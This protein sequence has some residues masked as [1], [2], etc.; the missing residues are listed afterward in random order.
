VEGGSLADEDGELQER[1]AGLLANT[2]ATPSDIPPSFS[3]IL[4]QLE[5]MDA[6]LLDRIFDRLNVPGRNWQEEAVDA[7]IA[8]FDAEVEGLSLE[9]AL[10]NLFRL[11]LITSQATYGE[12]VS[13][14]VMLTALGREFVTACR[15]PGALAEVQAPRGVVRRP[16]AG[17]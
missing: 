2:A 12:L 9:L 10:D 5:P 14:A 1:W 8:A 3:Y 15:P 17:S 6:R 7:R 13:E 4:G 16:T 11:R